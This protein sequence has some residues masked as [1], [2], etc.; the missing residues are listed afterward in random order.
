MRGG[1]YGGKGV[2]NACMCRFCCPGPGLSLADMVSDK[3]CHVTQ[4]QTPWHLPRRIICVG[5]CICNSAQHSAGHIKAQSM[6]NAVIM[7]LSDI[8][9][10]CGPSKPGV[11]SALLPGPGQQESSFQR[12][13]SQLGH[14]G[15]E[16]KPLCL[17]RGCES[18]K[19]NS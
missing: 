16:V 3:L 2:S 4:P 19:Q 9:I 18:P 12:K 1:C 13:V 8:A 14:Q 11:L 6:L 15:C 10:V 7:T 5:K 17:A